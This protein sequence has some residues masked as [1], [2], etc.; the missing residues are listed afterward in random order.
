MQSSGIRI[1]QLE[2][3]RALESVIAWLRQTREPA[4][5]SASGLSALSRLEALGSL[6][7]TELAQLEQLTQP[8]M[9]T[10]INRLEDAELATRE[11][12]PADRRAVRVTITAAGMERVRENR[13]ARAARLL[14]RIHQLS[15]NDQAALAAALPALRHF[16]TDSEEQNR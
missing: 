5:L 1:D 9:T 6:R 16:A 10:L 4:G 8:G 3:A 11:A 14:T 13:D 2:V 7:I 15:D 12:D